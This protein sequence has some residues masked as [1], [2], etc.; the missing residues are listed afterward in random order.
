M[1]IECCA[2]LTG[3]FR[4]AVVRA[5]RRRRV[6]SGDTTAEYVTALLVGCASVDA[7]EAL[8]TPLVERLDAALCASS[9][10][11]TVELQAV[12]DTALT[13]AGLFGDHVARHEG[14]LELYVT[15]GTFAYREALLAAR[16]KETVAAVPEAV[17]AISEDFST[18]VDVLA[19]VA[20]ASALGAVTKSVVQLYDRWRE[21]RSVKALEELAK[22]GVFV[23]GDDGLGAAGQGGG[24]GRGGQQ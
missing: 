24:L 4:D 21:A 17:E 10:E 16:V 1:T 7:I 13:R 14:V 6:E 19:E 9:V 2:D 3:F 5:M 15:V 18:Y 12:G 11:R 22:R 8:S 20:E 23:V